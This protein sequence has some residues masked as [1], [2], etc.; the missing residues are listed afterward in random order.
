MSNRKDKNKMIRRRMKTKMLKML[1]IPKKKSNKILQLMTM[2]LTLIEYSRKVKMAS[3]Q[4]IAS[5]IM[6]TL[7]QTVIFLISSPYLSNNK[8]FIYLDVGDASQVSAFSR[9]IPS[10][11]AHRSSTLND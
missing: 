5:S 1:W 3:M 7:S 11:K 9:V 10:F 6:T 8:N 4:P 2:V